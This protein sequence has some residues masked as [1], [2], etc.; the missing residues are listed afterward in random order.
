[1]R[2]VLNLKRAP[3]FEAWLAKMRV[4]DGHGALLAA[5]AP[6]LLDWIDS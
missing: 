2:R 6:P 5:S 3:E 1:V 4:T